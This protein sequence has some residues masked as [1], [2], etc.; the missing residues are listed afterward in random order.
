MRDLAVLNER[1]RAPRSFSSILAQG[2]AT[3]FG[4]LGDDELLGL[5]HHL[6]LPEGERLLEA[7][8]IEALQDGGHVEERSRLHQ[9]EVLLVAPLPVRRDVDVPVPHELEDLPDGLLRHRPADPEL[10]GG[11]AGQRDQRVVGDDPQV[12]DREPFPVIGLL[13]DGLDDAKALIR[14]DDLIADF[15]CFHFITLYPKEGARVN[16]NLR[17]NGLDRPEGFG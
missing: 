12:E 8:V 10:E 17:A 1:D 13:V 16:V 9:V 3:G 2:V 7:Q 4:D 11:G 14:I 15:Q 5:L 6:L